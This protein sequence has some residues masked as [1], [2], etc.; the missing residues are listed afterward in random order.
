M[1][2]LGQALAKEGRRNVCRRNL[3]S[4]TSCGSGTLKAAKFFRE[5]W[6]GSP[7]QFSLFLRNYIESICSSPLGMSELLTE[8]CDCVEQ[9]CV[10]QQCLGRFDGTC[11]NL[12]IDL[13]S[14]LEAGI[15]M[16]FASKAAHHTSI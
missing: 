10:I 3:A 2:D 15:A 7:F 14:R 13:S 5:I 1:F 12:T 16:M 11:K 4:C 8:P 9:C 6:H